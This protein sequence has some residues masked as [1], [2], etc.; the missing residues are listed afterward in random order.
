MA[1]DCS[2]SDRARASAGVAVGEGGVEPLRA[3]LNGTLDPRRRGFE[4]P[5]KKYK[6][7]DS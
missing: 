2:R 1:R 3:L 6:D 4:C 7:S 5:E